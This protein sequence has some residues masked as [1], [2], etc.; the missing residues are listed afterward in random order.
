[1]NQQAQAKKEQEEKEQ[2]E[3]E[4]QEQKE[5]ISKQVTP[6]QVYKKVVHRRSNKC[7]DSNGSNIYLG[8]CG[9]DYQKWTYENEK[10][11]HMKNNTKCLSYDNMNNNLIMVDCNDND[12][13]QKWV[14]IDDFLKNKPTG[15]CLDS[16][17]NNVYI[18]NCS[19]NNIYQKWD[20]LNFS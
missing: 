9:S 15:L 10:L 12:R 14:Q 3:K 11:R 18:R 2:K 8:S 1:M 7:L 4:E 16:D 19:D 17:E 13:L 6:P 20:I 5:K